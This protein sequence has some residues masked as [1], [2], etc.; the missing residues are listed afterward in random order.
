MKRPPTTPRPAAVMIGI[1]DTADPTIILTL[2]APTMP[3][4]AGQISLP[5]GTPK[6]EDD[7]PVGTALRETDEEI[8]V[9]PSA[10]NVR[11]TLG[12]HFGGLGYVVT[13]VVGLIDPSAEILPCPREVDEAFEVSFDAIVDPANHV[14]QDREFSGQPYKMFAVPVEDTQGQH[15]NIWGLTAGIL[16]T[17]SEI[18]HGSA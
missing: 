8:G 13:P 17:L 4:H 2:R 18:V 10:V 15:R 5:G 9:P 12:E 11:G 7:G 6:D 14:I 16:L 3:S 1:R